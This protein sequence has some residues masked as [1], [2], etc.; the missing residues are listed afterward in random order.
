MDKKLENIFTFLNANRQ[1]NHALQDKFYQSIIIPFNNNKDKIISLLYHI[2]NTQ[3]QPKIDK[4]ANFYKS[5]D[6]DMNCF[7][8][9][10][11]FIGKINPNNPIN[12]ES[13]YN[14]MKNQDG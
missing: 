1:F 11:N 10:D 13:L 4:L 12:F 2:A 7:S 14:V 5:I 8:T 6:Q 9:F 3:N